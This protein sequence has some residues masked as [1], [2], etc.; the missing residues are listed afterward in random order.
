MKEICMSLSEIRKN[1]GEEIA[2]ACEKM[3]HKEVKE[4]H[5]ATYEGIVVRCE[6][7]FWTNYYVRGELLVE[8]ALE[9]DYGMEMGM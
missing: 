4:F 2:N 1:F 9:M 6:K 5:T 3:E 8:E 7:S